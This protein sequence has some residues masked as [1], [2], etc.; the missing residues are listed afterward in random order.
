MEANPSLD[1]EQATAIVETYSS[2]P[3]QS[4]HQSGL[5]VDLITSTMSGL[6]ESFE[7]TD[8]FAWLQK[9]AAHFGFILRYPKGDD[10]ITG[11]TYEPWHYRFVGKAAAL[12]ITATGITLEEY[13][14]VIA[15]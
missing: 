5:C 15:P 13:L 8:A 10:G 14:G 4:E 9:N 6:D 7:K 12:E 2:R 11:Y 3:G 1:Q